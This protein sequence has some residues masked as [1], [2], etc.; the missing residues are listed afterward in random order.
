MSAYWHLFAPVKISITM[1]KN[2]FDDLAQDQV[3]L[4]RQFAKDFFEIN[5]DE[6][7]DENKILGTRHK[8][9]LT[10]ML[11]DEKMEQIKPFLNAAWQLI[12]AEDSSI[13]PEGL[14]D[15]IKDSLTQLNISRASFE[16]T[17]KRLKEIEH[18]Y[19]LRYES[20]PGVVVYHGWPDE[21]H[22]DSR[23]TS[24]GGF[25]FLNSYEKMN[26]IP[27]E[28]VLFYNLKDKIKNKLSEKYTIAKYIYT[29]GF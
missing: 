17:T 13:I 12:E 4:P 22:F 16:K 10:Y 18:N 24:M 15:F 21:L 6:Y 2:E 28:T 26:L 25:I 9:K 8:I 11:A 20:I 1:N 29:L 5:R 14:N 27:E 3:A 7:A 19:Y 23:N